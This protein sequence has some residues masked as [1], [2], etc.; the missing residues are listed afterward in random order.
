MNGRLE[1][2]LQI[3]NR[4]KESLKDLPDYVKSYYMHLQ[5]SK[6]ANTC[7]TYIQTVKRFIEY[8]GDTDINDVTE[9]TIQEFFESIKYIKKNGKLHRASAAYTKLSCSSL[10]S[11]FLFLYR[12]KIINN[13]PTEFIEMPT[14]KDSVKRVFFSMEDLTNLLNTVI[15]SN[16]GTYTWLLRDY[17]ILYLFMVTGMRKTA[18][19]EINVED[20]NL[21]ESTLKIIDKRDK[22]HIYILPEEIKKIIIKWLVYRRKYMSEQNFETDALFISQKHNRLS[23]T[24]VE[25]TVKYY[26]KRTFGEA[27]TPHKLRAAFISLYYAETHDIEAVRDAVGHADAKTTSRY[28]VRTNNPRKEAAEFMV[29]GLC[30][31]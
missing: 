23:P 4:T 31:K 30:H 1:H 8:I 9:D 3:N 25:R 18:L 12:R 19:S 16:R 28:I 24:A 27:Y 2:E 26:T 5:S 6:S 7:Y 13:N 14:R 17:T 10:N 15:D 29:N 11:F 22:E 21:D 20:L